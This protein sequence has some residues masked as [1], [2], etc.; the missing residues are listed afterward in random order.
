[1]GSPFTLESC[2]NGTRDVMYNG[3]VALHLFDY[4]TQ[5]DVIDIVEALNVAYYEGLCKD[6]EV[7]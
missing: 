2:G 6:S 7:Q 3:K 5:K 1:M 4:I